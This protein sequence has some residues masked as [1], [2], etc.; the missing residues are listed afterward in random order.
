MRKKKNVSAPLAC[1]DEFN[2]ERST[3]Q[4]VRWEDQDARRRTS[5]SHSHAEALRRMFKQ[6][7]KLTQKGSHDPW[8]HSVRHFGFLAPA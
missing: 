3:L 4:N 2:Y 6:T 7:F 5:H 8:I 1:P